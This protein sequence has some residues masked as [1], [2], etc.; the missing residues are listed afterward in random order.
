M[1]ANVSRR[2]WPASQPAD[3]VMNAT[4]VSETTISEAA[5]AEPEMANN[6]PIGNAG[7]SPA[8]AP[9]DLDRLVVSAVLRA[10]LA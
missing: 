1:V 7:S 10:T 9:I 6:S 2:G 8:A 3:V 5:A 4:R